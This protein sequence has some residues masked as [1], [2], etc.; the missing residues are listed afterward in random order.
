[1]DWAVIGIFG[2]NA[3]VFPDNNICSSSFLWRFAARRR[4]FFDLAVKEKSC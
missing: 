3:S 4:D 2:A 1:L